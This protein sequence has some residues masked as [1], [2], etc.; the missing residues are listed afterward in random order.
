MLALQEVRDVGAI[1]ALLGPDFEVVASQHGGPRGQHLVLAWRTSRIRP[2]GPPTEHDAIA[3]GGRLRPALS[4]P[5][6]LQPDGRPFTVMTVHLKARPQGAPI[7]ASQWDHLTSAVDQLRET[8]ADLVLV[9]DF[10]VTGGTSLGTATDERQALETK[11]TASN[12]TPIEVGA[13]TSYWHGVRHDRWV[14]PARLD[15]AFAAGFANARPVASAGTHC[16]RNG[17]EPFAD[18]D[19][20]PS[21]TGLSDHCPVVVDMIQNAGPADPAGPSRD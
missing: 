15:L 16:R 12:L 7:R 6:V 21:F 5:F 2:T 8:V 3:M 1:A 19:L 9:G 18:A 11:L 13:C 4:A 17:C 14:E 20:D 10:N